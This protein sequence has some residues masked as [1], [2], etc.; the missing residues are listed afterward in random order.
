MYCAELRNNQFIESHSYQ[1]TLLISLFTHHSSAGLEE[2]VEAELGRVADTLAQLI[3]N[4]LLI[5]AQLVKHADEEAVLFFS[6]VLPLV[7]PIGDPQLVEWGLVTANL[8]QQKNTSEPEYSVLLPCFWISFFF[9]FAGLCRV[10][11]IAL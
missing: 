1:C 5:E 6:V 3:V 11:K 10:L 4:A 9:F 7:G 8:A 2:P